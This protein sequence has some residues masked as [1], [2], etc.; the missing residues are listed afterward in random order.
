MRARTIWF[1]LAC[2]VARKGRSTPATA[3]SDRRSGATVLI[4]RQRRPN[5]RGR[6][7]GAGCLDALHTH[8]DP[9]FCPTGTG[10]KSGFNSVYPG[11]SSVKVGHGAAVVAGVGPERLGRAASIE[12][13]PELPDEIPP[14][15]ALGLEARCVWHREV[16]PVPL[17][18]HDRHRAGASIGLAGS[19]LRVNLDDVRVGRWLLPNGNADFGGDTRQIPYCVAAA[20]GHA[21][22]S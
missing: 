19:F 10:G 1:R 21:L 15:Y 17:L 9:D 13:P 22:R 20:V 14:S 16:H 7:Q 12:V 8:P 6:Q 2:S 11:R 4:R 18:E 5:R 3:A